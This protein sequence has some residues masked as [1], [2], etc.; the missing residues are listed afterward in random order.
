MLLFFVF[1]VQKRALN[2][3]L[4][5]IVLLGATATRLLVL[6]LLLLIA[7]LIEISMAAAALMAMRSKRFVASR[8]VE[9]RGA[10]TP[11][12]ARGQDAN[13]REEVVNARQTEQK[14]DCF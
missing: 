13:E 4:K 11:N 1:V 2:Y 14:I 7:T 5:P 9:L 12:E 8:F 3:L 10:C 6:L